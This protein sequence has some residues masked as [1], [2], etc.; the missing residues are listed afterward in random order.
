M[1]KNIPTVAGLEPAIFGFEVQRGIHFATRSYS[2]DDGRAL[3]TVFKPSFAIKDFCCPYKF[4][5]ETL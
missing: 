3:N 5:F 4:C 1:Q 2:I